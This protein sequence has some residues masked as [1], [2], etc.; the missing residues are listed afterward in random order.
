MRK[1]LIFILLVCVAA[2]VVYCQRRITPVKNRSTVT[3]S[4]NQ[5]KKDSLDRTNVIEMT[6][7][8]G[9]VILIDTITGK[10][11]VDSTAIRQIPKMIY[12]LLHSVSVGIDL[13]SPLMR[14]FNTTYGL[15]GFSGQVSLHNR[16]IPTVEIGLGKAEDTPSDNNYTYKS[17]MSVYFKLGADY[18][19]LYNSNPDY[20]FYAGARFGFSP[21]KYQLTNVTLN[22]PYWNESQVVDF[23]A[24]NVTVAYFE[25]LFGLRVQ[26]YKNW[27]MGWTFR[28]H[29]IIKDAKSEYGEPWYIPGYGT[30]GSAIGGSF[31]IFYTLPFKEKKKEPEVDPTLGQL[32]KLDIRSGENGEQVELPDT[33]NQTD[34]ISL[35]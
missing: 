25:F 1:L 23:P 22:D 20:F 2:E 33:K 32:P 14:L 35:Q 12:P 34:S 29:S 7:A 10:E 21:F 28:Y 9:K 3:Q 26:I 11:V 18:N 27:A 17:P 13:W 31:S 5:S 4:I 16:Y 6:D 19:F 8:N 24:Q 30:R 15:I